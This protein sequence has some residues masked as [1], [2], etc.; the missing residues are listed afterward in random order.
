MHLNRERRGSSIISIFNFAHYGKLGRWTV[1]NGTP[2]ALAT[3]IEVDQ[4]INGQQ[5]RPNP[6]R[7]DDRELYDSYCLGTQIGGVG[8]FLSFDPHFFSRL[9]QGPSEPSNEPSRNGRDQGSVQI[10]S[11]KGTHSNVED[12]IVTG[13]ILSAAWWIAYLCFRGISR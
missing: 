12:Y 10:Q 3:H 9:A 8:C 7:A 11:I 13:A 2:I 5:I 6:K 1:I 4:S